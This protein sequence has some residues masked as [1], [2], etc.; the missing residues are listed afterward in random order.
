M[1]AQLDS[2]DLAMNYQQ[3]A[4]YS[5]SSNDDNAGEMSE[6][7]ST[8]ASGIYSEFEKMIQKHGPDVVEN[9]MPM[10]VNVLEQLE[11]SYSEGNEQSM[12]LEMI[13]EDNEQLITQYERE[14]QLR[15]L[16]EA[17]YL[18][19]ED[20]RE[21]DRS[22]LQSVIE[23]LEHQRKQ[24]ESKIKNFQDQVDRL[25]ER[26]SEQKREYEVLHTRHTE[27]LHAYMERME[28][29]AKMS[30]SSA[31][32]ETNLGFRKRL[33]VA[34]GLV[35]ASQPNLAVQSQQEALKSASST[36]IL[37]KNTEVVESRNDLSFEDEV[38][39]EEKAFVEDSKLSTKQLK[40]LPAPD[41]S[42][43]VS[44]EIVNTDNVKAD[45]TVIQRSKATSE[46]TNNDESMFFQTATDIS[47]VKES[48]IYLSP[49]A[50][51]ILHSTPELMKTE[52][53]INTV[54][55][56]ETPTIDIQQ[57]Q[58]VQQNNVSLFAE[59]ESEVVT[60]SD[61]ETN[62]MQLVGQQGL[63][64]FN[65][66]LDENKELTVIRD[67]LQTQKNDLLRRVEE[68]S[69]E[70]E[71]Q[72]E[73]MHGL[74][75][76]KARMKLKI[77]EL[78]QTLKKIR[79]EN[80]K[81]QIQ[82]KNKTTQEQISSANRKR[83]TRVEMAKVL[84]ER[85]Q[86][87]ERLME[88][89]EAVR[90]TEMIR[91]SKE[92]HITALQQKKKSSSI[93]K[94]FSNLFASSSG[95][96]T[97]S[98]KK[99]PPAQPINVW[100][101]SQGSVPVARRHTS[102]GLANMSN[103]P[104][105]YSGESGFEGL[106]ERQ[107]LERKERYKIVKEH[108]NSEGRKQAYGWS[109]PANYTGDQ[110]G[111]MAVP[112]PVYCRPLNTD[113][114]MKIWCASGVNLTGGRTTGGNFVGVP[115]DFK[116]PSTSTVWIGTSTHSCSKVTIIDSNNPSVALDQFIVSSSHLLCMA[117]VAGLGIEDAAS[118][119]VTRADLQRS[120]RQVGS[121]SGQ[122]QMS[123][124]HA[125][126]V[127]GIQAE[128]ESF[129]DDD[130]V[131]GS[132]ILKV[133]SLLPTMWLGA[134]SG[135][136][137]IHSVV[138]NWKKCLQSAKLKDSLLSIVHT[139]GRVLAALADGTVAIFHRKPDGRWDLSNYHLLDLGRPHHSI[140]CMT[141]VQ[142]HVWCGYR[143]KV[144]VINPRTMKIEKSFD[145]H[146]RRES[147]VRQ[148]ACIGDGVWVS[149]RLDSTLRLYNAH[150]YH[151]L[152]DV[153]IEP[154]VSK[155]LGTSKLGFSF[156]RITA[157]LLTDD[158]LWVG[159]GNG[160]VLSVPLVSSRP[161]RESE[162]DPT[163]LALSSPHNGGREKR[164]DSQS[165][166]MPYCAMVHA[167][168]SFHGHRDSVKFFIAVPGSAANVEAAK[169]YSNAGARPPSPSNVGP[170][171]GEDG[172][173]LVMSGGEGYID[174]RVGDD[175]PSDQSSETKG[176]VMVERSHLLVWQVGGSE[177]KVMS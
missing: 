156:V 87:K 52:S 19:Y 72:E 98:P 47:S 91:A 170:N 50:K 120:S 36:Q 31:S 20:S 175:E 97:T 49:E 40:K 150:T 65:L 169:A 104:A 116:E 164:S 75:A 147:Q 29:Q 142:D 37:T 4:V 83:F 73:E 133:S 118:E 107:R 12:E 10:V 5:N 114:A 23:Q 14:K 25:E 43:S 123:P 131:D 9:L 112:I 16:A 130:V 140:R 174:F 144:Q 56:Q 92:N 90:W 15:K 89:Q 163:K 100:Y 159:T 103:Y 1:D 28:M 122:R 67:K 62:E 134:Q 71:L 78:E 138:T 129:P 136:V 113:P 148:L 44:H 173:L 105:R 152:Q 94:L 167:Q 108:I 61:M 154:Y 111:P 161:S 35:S 59:L 128:E 18:E 95:S 7:V 30:P 125:G 74:Q 88:L 127:M 58:K 146:P 32:S 153:D 41:L 2:L 115:L 101:G 60:P 64:E 149:I 177:D 26:C 33:G 69:G 53:R 132:H 124:D 126:S 13:A 145:A 165:L 38:T 117:A 151:H 119:G 139:H 86:Y 102:V 63:R 70:N 42:R 106:T 68:L 45:S 21:Q 158:R 96:S 141:Q 3:E 176:G 168:L 171:K 6:R 160:T 155:M 162:T 80:D 121:S 166:F 143:N 27:M 22:E 11:S 137:Y 8:L 17:K 82:L 24:A 77:S 84:M 79:L 57:A 85:N 66:L 54:E 93:W 135:K 109:L 48:E 99:G 55:F 110:S 81:A 34:Q 76:T 39:N 46:D 172:S 157:L 51:A